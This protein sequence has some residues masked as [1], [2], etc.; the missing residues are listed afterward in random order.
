[1]TKRIF[2][3]YQGIVNQ[4]LISTQK[5]NFTYSNNSRMKLG[6]VF[7]TGK[8]IRKKFKKNLKKIFSVSQS[9]F[10]LMFKNVKSPLDVF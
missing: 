3:L 2:Y 5:R 10:K 9:A 1:M 4:D 6:S 7:H 8:L